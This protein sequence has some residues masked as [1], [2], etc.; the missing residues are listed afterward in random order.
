[1]G[2]VTETVER[3]AQLH[4]GGHLADVSFRVNPFREEDKTYATCEDPTYT[5][6]IAEHLDGSGEGKTLGVYPLWKVNGV[7]M[8]N[9]VAVDLDEGKTS[10]VHAD[11]LQKILSAKGIPSFK[12][13]SKSKGYHVWVYLDQ[14]IAASIGRKGMIGACRIVDVPIK[15][16]YPK[17]TILP[18]GK[19][20]NCLRLPY[21]HSRS[22]GRH[23]VY[24]P[25]VSPPTFYD[26]ESFVEAAWD[27]RV[28]LPV[29][30]ELVRLYE[31]TEPKA[32]QYSGGDRN[33][34]EFYGTARKIWDQTTFEDR[35]A[36][37][38][39]FAGSLLWQGYSIDATID[40]VRKLD[41]RLG[42]YVDRAE[43]EKY[44]RDLVE[45]ASTRVEPREK[46]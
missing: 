32:P 21:P 46:T 27:N 23:E 40:W 5:Q 24:V 12:E 3:F 39:A 33:D 14:P 18:E 9:W 38:F 13:T 42:K 34:G 4:F 1:M 45:S 22:T 15:E 28:S 11:N 2:S 8:V 30:R 25:D 20:G 36:A 44:L 6:R 31:A 17:Q 16:V 26:A 19:I 10:D 41:D 43:R 7:W 37:M 29:F 35:S